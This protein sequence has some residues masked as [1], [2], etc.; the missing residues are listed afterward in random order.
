MGLTT[1][2]EFVID[3]L[4]EKQSITKEKLSNALDQILSSEGIDK[5]LGLLIQEKP[6]DK[7]L[8]KGYRIS[9]ISIEPDWNSKAK[10]IK[11]I[12]DRFGTGLKGAKDLVDAIPVDLPFVM[13]HKEACNI[14]REL[15]ELGVKTAT[16]FY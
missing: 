15:T 11:F 2:Q 9:L 4:I 16:T 10:V 13:S 6:V 12:R 7:K 14:G 3:T 8:N 1:I 5:F